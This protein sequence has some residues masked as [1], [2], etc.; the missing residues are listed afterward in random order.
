[1]LM[2]HDTQYY[3]YRPRRRSI[4]IRRV[5]HAHPL[6]QLLCTGGAS[7]PHLNR[8]RLPQKVLCSR[9][10][11]AARLSTVCPCACP[12][13]LCHGVVV[14]V[15]GEF[16]FDEG[17]FRILRTTFVLWYERE[18]EH[19]ISTILSKQVLVG[20]YLRVCNLGPPKSTVSPS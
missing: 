12:C 2:R 8:L 3:L 18:R 6:P 13:A 7:R 17:V 19:S 14:A 10:L 4:S 15:D 5:S 1:M 11:H 9:T 16:G 20:R